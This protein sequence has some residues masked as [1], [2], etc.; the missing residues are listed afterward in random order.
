LRFAKSEFATTDV[1]L[2]FA[3][4]HRFKYVV[5]FLLDVDEVQVVAVSHAAREPGYWL[6]RTK[7]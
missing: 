7:R 5:H 4:V 3:I 1:D 2:R 6:G